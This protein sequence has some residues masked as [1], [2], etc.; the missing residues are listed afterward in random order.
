MLENDSSDEEQQQPVDT[1]R[2]RKDN[3]ALIQLCLDVELKNGEN[4][5]AGLEDGSSERLA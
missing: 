2:D 4:E 3:L 5:R 1:A